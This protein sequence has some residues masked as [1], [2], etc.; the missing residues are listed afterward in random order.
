M[1]AGTNRGAAGGILVRFETLDGMVRWRNVPDLDHKTLCRAGGLCESITTF[2][3]P[4]SFVGGSG[5]GTRRIEG[6]IFQG[7]KGT[8]PIGKVTLV[9]EREKFRDE[10]HLEYLRRMGCEVGR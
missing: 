5:R 3:V 10:D 4:K 2:D 7:P 9:E 1:S 8:P 6:L